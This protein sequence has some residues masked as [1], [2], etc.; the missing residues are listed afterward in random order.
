MDS[1]SS[2][3]ALAPASPGAV[4]ARADRLLRTFNA[5]T[6]DDLERRATLL[7]AADCA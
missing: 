7:R 5:T 6:V 4:I 3:I 2:L 1:L